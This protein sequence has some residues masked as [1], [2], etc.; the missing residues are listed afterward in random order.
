[1]KHATLL[2]VLLM[3]ATCAGRASA[4]RPLCVAQGERTLRVQVLALLE[5]QRVTLRAPGRLELPGNAYLDA[6]DEVSVSRDGGGVVASDA[7]GW[8]WRGNEFAVDARGSRLVLVVQGRD[9]RSRVATGVVS[10]TSKGGV[11]EVIAAM[12]LEQLVASAVSAELADV[13]DSAALEAT[14]IALRSYLVTRTAHRGQGFDVCD[15]THCAHSQGA[16]DPDD[17]HDRVAIDAC[18]RSEGLV[19]MVNGDVLP[20]YCTASCGGRTVTPADVWGSRAAGYASVR[21]AWCRT[22]AY[23]R[24]SRSLKVSDVNSATRA[25]TGDRS[26]SDIDVYVAALRSG[27]AA[28]VVVRSNGRETEVTGDAFRLSVGRRLGWDAIPSNKFQ[29][30]RRRDFYVIRGSGYGHCIGLCL[31]GAVTLAREGRDARAII[32]TYFPG[33]GIAQLP[34]DAKNV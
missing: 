32:A 11:L 5:P 27:V 6:G 7:R 18:R 24:W 1:M 2:A 8:R 33:A 34:V 4:T 26:Q 13:D 31:A 16:P 17:A 25:L 22:S 14:A 28:D 10:I 15:S 23:Y 20:G 12:P 21:C 29:I 3:S 19:L 9:V 30:E